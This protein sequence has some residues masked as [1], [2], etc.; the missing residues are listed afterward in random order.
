M[1]VG[2]GHEY[3]KKEVQSIN[4]WLKENS[5]DLTRCEVSILYA[6]TGGGRIG[7]LIMWYWLIY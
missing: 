1:F 6:Y 5:N 2:G 3:K 7:Y 4:Y